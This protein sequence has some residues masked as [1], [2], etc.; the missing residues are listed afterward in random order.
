VHN[1]ST[2]LT[3]ESEVNMH[4]K[5]GH[6]N[7]STTTDHKHMALLITRVG[8]V[9]FIIPGC[10]QT[11]NISL[12]PDQ[13]T[14]QHQTCKQATHAGTQKLTIHKYMYTYLFKCA[15]YVSFLTCNWYRD[16][17]PSTDDGSLNQ[18]MSMSMV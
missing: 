11:L 14:L 16:D 6:I 15:V 12:Q 8:G 3:N 18:N 13:Y 2:I 17:H 10:V 1:T 9:F 7:T 4:S 5:K